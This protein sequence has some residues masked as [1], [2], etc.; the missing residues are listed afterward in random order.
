MKKYEAYFFDLY[1]TLIDIH[2]DEE[3]PAFWRQLA[4]FFCMHGADYSQK[5][6][7]TAYL[8][9]VNVDLARV[10]EYWKAK[11]IKVKYPEPDI[12]NVFAS[13]YA[14]KNIDVNPD[15]IKDTA[16]TFRKTS[17][18]HLRLYAGAKDLLTAL[19]NSGSKVILLSN[20]QS[21]FTLPE[22]EQLEIKSSFDKIYISSNYGI[23]KPDPLFFQ[24]ALKDQD[25]NPEDAIMIGNEYICD[26]T[27]ASSAN[28][29]SF[30]ILDKLSTKEE[31]KNPEKGRSTCF[32]EG[33]DL[34]KVK[35]KL[36]KQNRQ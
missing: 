35:R 17:T 18:T 6:L 25:L 30:Y 27:G 2:T 28:M 15:L 11:D 9:A 8:A 36:L 21:L 3:S 22:L 32:Q 24:M 14:L 23:K 20:A 12:G 13:L 10:K 33:M 7:K 31:K 34:R 19:R 16:W 5:E 1:G 29:D 26:I 4:G